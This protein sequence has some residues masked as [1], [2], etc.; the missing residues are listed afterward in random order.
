MGQLR[1][2]QISSQQAYLEVLEFLKLP[3]M[4]N[5]SQLEF[6]VSKYGNIHKVHSLKIPDFWPLCLPLFVFEY[7]PY[8]STLNYWSQSTHY[9]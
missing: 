8:I 4:V 1:D 2:V 7:A 9:L 6:N 5:V 3:E